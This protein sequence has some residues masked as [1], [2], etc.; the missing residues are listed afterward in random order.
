MNIRAQLSTFAGQWT[1]INRLW[2]SPQDPANE[3]ETTASIALVARDG[4]A[5]VRYTW[6]YDGRP[7]DGLLLVRNDAEPSPD[8]M[9][10][11][12]SWHTGG[13]LMHLRGEESTD[14]RISAFGTY[15]APPGPDWGWRIVLAA[16]TADEVRILM[17]NV[18]PDGD[19][20]LAVEA[21]YARANA[22]RRVAAADQ[23][24]AG[25]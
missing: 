25:Y 20:A 12:D 7:E 5:T 21:R 1:G 15:A 8:D 17:Y 16:D 19:E 2:L 6:A 13:K 9:V 24:A 23:A 14:G 18:S 22:A 4:F 11:V 10:W 3:S